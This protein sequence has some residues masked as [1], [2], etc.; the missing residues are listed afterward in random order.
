MIVHDEHADHGAD[1]TAS[2]TLTVISVPCPGRL[3]HAELTAEQP[4]ALA[5]ADQPVPLG[6]PLVWVEPVPIVA[7]RERDV[8]RRARELDLHLTGARVAAHVRER[9]LRDPVQLG[10][11]AQRHVL[12]RRRRARARARRSPR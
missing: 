7:E 1:A 6:L 4:R 8:A 10:L 2:G 11:D 9:L 12:R 3:A 5:H